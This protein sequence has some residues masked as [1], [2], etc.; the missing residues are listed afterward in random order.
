MS[1]NLQ[2]GNPKLLESIFYY[3]KRSSCT[4]TTVNHILVDP[5]N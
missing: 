1:I 4:P 5:A 3:Y 2:Y